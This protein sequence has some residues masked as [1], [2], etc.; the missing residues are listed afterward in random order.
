LDPEI[1]ASRAKVQDTPVLLTVRKAMHL[2]VTRT[3]NKLG[4]DKN[5][6]KPFLD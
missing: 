4:K 3:E 1:A 6:R 2:W 5:G